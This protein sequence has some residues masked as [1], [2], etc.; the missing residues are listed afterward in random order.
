MKEHHQ[1]AFGSKTRDAER[2]IY[3]YNALALMKHELLS[4]GV[5][6]WKGE[7]TE[8]EH[9]EI[10][11]ANRA[12]ET[13]LH[14]AVQSGRVASVRA[15]LE[16]N[17]CTEV[18]NSSGQT[19]LHLACMQENELMVRTLL[20]AKANPDVDNEGKTCL[21]IAALSSPL[22]AAVFKRI[23]ADGWTPLMVAAE[24][25]GSAVEEYLLC[26]ESVLSLQNREPFRLQEHFRNEVQFYCGLSQV[27]SQLEWG[28]KWSS[29]PGAYA[30]NLEAVDTTATVFSCALGKDMFSGGIHIWKVLV[31]NFHSKKAWI[32][33]AR[34]EN[35]TC[36]LQNTKSSQSCYIVYFDSEG[37]EGVVGAVQQQSKPVI[38][39]RAGD[40]SFSSGQTVELCLD[41]FKNSLELRIDGITKRVAHNIDANRIHPYVR[42]EKF[43]SATFMYS[44]SHNS[45]LSSVVSEGEISAGF[46]NTLW[47]SDLDKALI[48]CFKSGKYSMI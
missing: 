19:A 37:A 12:L 42:F 2:S 4:I 27:E 40:S 21:E 11:Q 7:L 9:V 15:L 45:I 33:V 10:D 41:T 48:Q 29:A 47:S 8:I 44:R 38:F 30:S 3:L 36:D 28:Q 32:G 24:K 39:D 22:C 13:A 35:V 6:D 26:R 34:N 18:K 20:A 25:G 23:G 1:G 17:A 46:D 43:G 16:A 14:L 31:T 5:K